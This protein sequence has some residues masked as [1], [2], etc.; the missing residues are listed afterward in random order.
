MKT[1]ATTTSQISKIENRI[2]KLQHDV[3][4]VNNKMTVH[5]MLT[6]IEALKARKFDLEAELCDLMGLE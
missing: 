1:I 3:E 6:E 4:Y 5:S 2:V